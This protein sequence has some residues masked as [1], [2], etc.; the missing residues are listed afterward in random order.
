MPKS[1]R[2]GPRHP[3]AYVPRR[4]L[5]VGR[6]GAALPAVIIVVG[7]VM[8]IRNPQ[9]LTLVG[10][11]FMAVILVRSLIWGRGSEPPVIV[12]ELGITFSDIGD[13]GGPRP[14]PWES[15]TAVVLF[16]VQRTDT[17]SRRWQSAIGVRLAGHPDGVSV[18]RPLAGWSH[19]R[20]AL[21]RAVTRFGGDDVRV[22]DGPRSSAEP[23]ADQVRTEVR[24]IAIDAIR[25][26]R[27]P[28]EQV[29]EPEQRP[30]VEW[31]RTARHQPADLGAYLARFDLR[32]QLGLIVAL[33][34]VQL[35]FWLI[36]IPQAGVGGVVAAVIFALPLL[37]I[38][39]TLR[40]GG[41]VAFA[42]DRAGVFFGESHSPGDDHDHRLLAWP[43]IGAVV[44]YDQLVKRSKGAD[45][46][47]RAV[48]V[49]LRG[50][51]TLVGHW[52]I[53]DG[54]H[55]DR[56]ALEAAVAR[57]GS[58]VTVLDGPPQRPPSAS[59]VLRGLYDAGREIYDE[60]QRNRPRGWP[61]G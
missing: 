42:V 36:V 21:E 55:L 34:G 35:I 54:W 29:Q 20:A 14:V 4:K 7:L 48:G 15:I 17:T 49:R 18:H 26:A 45:R 6:P 19:D 23:T 56:P 47:K 10:L 52:R 59:G 51:P 16:D 9:P 60:E 2:V 39:R 46:W 8:T 32:S 25:Q 28:D 33:L 50:E 57:F 3:D 37:L 22:V 27:T 24:R 43:D 11:V 1:A 5:V 58:G 30:R 12:D 61:E 53:I 44:V 31:H 40:A 41:A 13:G 38:W